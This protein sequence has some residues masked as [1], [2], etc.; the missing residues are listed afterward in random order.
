MERI[1]SFP[2]FLSAGSI[3]TFS[4]PASRFDDG[5]NVVLITISHSD[6]GPATLRLDFDFPPHPQP[7]TSKNYYMTIQFGQSII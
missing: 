7:P 6:C 2:F 3:P 1:D 5:A 4:V